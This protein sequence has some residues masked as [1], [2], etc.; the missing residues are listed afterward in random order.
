MSAIVEF[1]KGWKTYAVAAAT[2]IVAFCKER[3]G[4]DVPE[5]VWAALAAAG[6]AFLRAGVSKAN[7]PKA[8]P[9][10]KK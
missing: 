9:K 2:V 5:F 1:L 8:D 4:V 7:E 6:L 10:K 3:F